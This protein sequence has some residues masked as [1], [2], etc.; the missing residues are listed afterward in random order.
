VDLRPLLSPRSVAVIGA[1]QKGGRATG[2]VRNLLEL[3]FKGGIYPVNPKYDTVLDLPCYPRLDAI[4][5]P[6]DLVAIGIPSEQIIP[7]LEEANRK[8]IRAAV[9]FAS[10]FG[11]AGE[12]GRLRQAEIEEFARRSNMLICG[13]NCLGVINFQDRSAGYSSTS[14]KDVVAGDVAVV[15]QSGTI[16]VALVRSLRGIGFSHM[17]SCGNE[18]TIASSDYLRYLVDDPGTKVIGAFLEEIKRP[19]RLVEA[20]EAARRQGKPLIV[21]KTGRSEQGRAASLAH[22]GSLAG[23]YDV[24]RALFRQKGVVQCDDLDEWIEAIELFRYA[25]APKADGV[26]I[27]GLSGGENALVLDHAADIGL[28]V[29]TLS[30]EGKQRLAG[31]LPWYARAENPID[32]T[33]A[34]GNDPD[35]FRKSLEVLLDEPEIGIVAVSQDSPAH[36]DLAVAK[37]TARM[38]ASAT[39]PLVFFS[40]ISGPYRSEVQAILRN[41]GVPYLQGVR[42]S[43]KA[44]KALIDYHRGLA[45]SRA[46]RPSRS[47]SARQGLARKIL[48][49]AGPAMT[50]DTAKNLLKLY[51]FPVVEERLVPTAAEAGR[52][53]EEIGFPVV[54]KVVSPDIAHKATLG[55]VRLRLGS[56]AE[57]QAAAESILAD[58]SKRS[59]A[60]RIS[61]LLVQPMIPEGLELIFGMKRDKQFGSTVVFGLG[62]VFVEAIRQVSIRV[63]PLSESDARAMVSELPALASVLKKFPAAQDAVESI[64]ALLLRLSD[65]AVELGDEIGE[66]DV[67]PVILDTDTGKMTVVD[68][69]VLKRPASQS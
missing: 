40:N 11:E 12:L 26:G 23:S 63:A 19:E 66:I 7:V 31:I 62:G 8:Q 2:A 61:G 54:A 52:A 13:P 60:A 4:P 55:G 10:G 64:V 65:L 3:G 36:F 20:A 14:P 35:I 17:V 67:N 49:E 37:D 50:E 45:E 46:I 68:A 6:V 47:D 27:I 41:A 5:G 59:P 21:V 42:E 1:S 16:I 58:V 33:G 30:A 53:A 18:A 51:G 15:S 32:P 38:A 48:A 24:Q 34:M 57:V 25:R 22:T 9:I 43:L 29:P 44:I 39:K 28:N 56:R 69:L